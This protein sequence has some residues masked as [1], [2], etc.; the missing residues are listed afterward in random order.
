MDL[1]Q[2]AKQLEKDFESKVTLTKRDNKKIINKVI[3]GEIENKIIRKTNEMYQKRKK[4]SQ[5]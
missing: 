3:K 5:E 4:G 2:T 1:F